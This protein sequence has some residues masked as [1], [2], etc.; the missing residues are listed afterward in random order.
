MRDTLILLTACL[1]FAGISFR[2]FATITV[3]DFGSE[4]HAIVWAGEFNMNPHVIKAMQQKIDKIEDELLDLKGRAYNEEDDARMA[5]LEDQI[6]LHHHALQVLKDENFY[7]DV[8]S[9]FIIK[10]ELVPRSPE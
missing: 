7:E 3:P 9:V 5:Y 10:S 6:E 2:D 8:G 1:S 4:A